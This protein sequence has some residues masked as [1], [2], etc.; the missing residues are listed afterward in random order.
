MTYL[1]E[2]RLKYRFSEQDVADVLKIS[3]YSYR[4]YESG[5]RIPPDV[6]ARLGEIYMRSVDEIARK[7]LE[8][9]K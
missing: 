1:E 3:L 4:K 8:S 7:Q 5:N 9:L 6:L 2:L